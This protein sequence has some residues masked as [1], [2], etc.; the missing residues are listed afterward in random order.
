MLLF[1]SVLVI[2]SVLPPVRF[3]LGREF[4]ALVEGVPTAIDE[5]AEQ[6]QLALFAD[7]EGVQEA[8]RANPDDLSE[9]ALKVAEPESASLLRS[10]ELTT[11]LEG[12]RL[13]RILLDEASPQPPR[14]RQ[15]LNLT[16]ASALTDPG[17]AVDT[18][19][20]TRAGKAGGA[21]RYR[22]ELAEIEQ[23]L[24]RAAA[25]AIKS[26]REAAD[27]ANMLRSEAEWA[28]Q[29][30][31]VAHAEIRRLEIANAEFERLLVSLQ[32]EARLAREPGPQ[33]I[34][35]LPE[36]VGAERPSHADHLQ[37]GPDPVEYE[38]PAAGALPPARTSTG[39]E[40]AAEAGVDQP[41]A[42]EFPVAVAE[43]DATTSDTE[44]ALAD[45]HASV[46]ALNALERGES[47]IDLFSDI[48][49]VSGGA[50]HISATQG[51]NALPPIARQTYLDMLL[52]DWVAA[53]GGNGPAVVRILDQHGQV[54]REKSSP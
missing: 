32:A 11:D 29:E 27:E 16:G 45:L 7:L 20:E 12:A 30:L 22:T 33:Q 28:R 3:D 38:E 50:V 42:S 1:L 40:H 52:E 53:Q 13:D 41:N 54:L 39:L 43:P 25:A 46:Q 26:A 5:R 23:Q 14:R 51:W 24:S 19:T 36:V 44:S 15:Q 6:H 18:G 47:G 48:E 8:P 49:S 17:A 2:V 31:S 4:D 10:H 21:D 37:S 34:S 9:S 35:D